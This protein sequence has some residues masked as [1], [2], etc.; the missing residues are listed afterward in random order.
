MGEKVKIETPVKFCSSFY[1]PFRDAAGS[2]PQF[3]DRRNYQL[4][5]PSRS[6]GLFSNSTETLSNDS[7]PSLDLKTIIS[8]EM[9]RQRCR[10]RRRYAYGQTCWCI[11]R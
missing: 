11:F 6:L 8:F 10:G 4:P 2:A 5:P 9:Y 7:C 3:G 1:G